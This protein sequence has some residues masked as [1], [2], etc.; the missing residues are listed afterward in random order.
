[1]INISNCD[2]YETLNL[3]I[4]QLWPIMAG[5]FDSLVVPLLQLNSRQQLDNFD[6]KENI[7]I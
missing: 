4:A 2:I 1:M 6:T 5:N 3:F 7:Q